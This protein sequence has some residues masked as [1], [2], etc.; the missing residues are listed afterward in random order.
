MRGSVILAGAGPGDPDLLTVAALRA[1]ETA[2]VIFYDELVSEEVLRR[3]GPKA[4]LIPVGKRGYRPSCKQSH[5]NEE[6]V[7]W[8]HEGNR[9]V[10][11]KSGDPLIF[12]RAGEEIEACIAAGVEVAVIPG[13]T[14]AQGAAAR[15]CTSLTHRDHARRV[16]FIT[17]HD[18]DGRLPADMNW[19]AI[20]DPSVTTVVYMPLRTVRE[21][22]AKA[23]EAGLP[24][25]TPAVA[26]ANATRG[27]ERILHSTIAA[28]A[29]DLER[30]PPG[31]PVL[32]MIGEVFAKRG[33]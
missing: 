22:S 31:T 6:I 19:L 33:A 11:L 26:I 30:D 21:L 2:D 3:A 29:D 9:V 12:G 25:E 32:V 1:I 23:I 10:R 20:A 7:R 15:L 16:Q 28:I 8:A 4:K 5:I 18:R 17:G 13:V 14:S 27:E 24:P